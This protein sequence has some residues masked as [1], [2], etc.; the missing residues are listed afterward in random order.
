[1]KSDMPSCVAENVVC[2]TTDNKVVSSFPKSGGD[3]N[4]INIGNKS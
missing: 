3:T 1:M 2:T 4:L